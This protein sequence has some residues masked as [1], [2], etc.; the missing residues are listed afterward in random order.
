MLMGSIAERPV[1]YSYFGIDYYLQLDTSFRAAVCK[2]LQRK[3]ESKGC[4]CY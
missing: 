4:R 3:I 1:Q 2:L